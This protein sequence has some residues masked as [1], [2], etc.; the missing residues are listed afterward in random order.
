MIESL[1]ALLTDP[2]IPTLHPM[3]IHFPIAL[4]CLAPLFDLACLV[5]RSRLWLDRTAT[6]LYLVGTLGA[7]VAYLSGQRAAEAVES[8]TPAAESILADHEAQAVLTL[9]VLA[10]AALLRL[11]VTWLGRDDRRIKVGIFRLIALP[12]AIAALVM[13]V[14]TADLGGQLVYKHGVGVSIDAE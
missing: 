5:F 10:V 2:G 14:L 4:V 9:I 13:M 1:R 12:A 8:L 3:V 11:M 7:G 6:T